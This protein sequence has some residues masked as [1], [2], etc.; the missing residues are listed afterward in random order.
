[1]PHKNYI[2]TEEH[3]ANIGLALK[4]R[5]FTNTWRQNL[6]NSLLGYKQTEEHKHKQSLVMLGNQNALGYRHTKE[7]KQKIREKRWK[8]IFPPKDTYIEIQLQEALSECNI[9]YEKH[10]PIIG[11]PDIFI[12]PN[13][14]IF[15]DGKYWHT[16]PGRQGYDMIVNNELRDL[17]YEVIRFW[18][19]DIRNNVGS[20]LE[21]IMF[22][23][24]Q[25][26]ERNSFDDE[27]TISE[28]DK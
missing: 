9:E 18:G 14:C 17:G 22:K 12:K 21:K 10:K 15:A 3:R 8:Q 26:N 27:I 6:S 23:L 24:H 13:I 20:C 28:E 4:G 11:Q 7:A 1:M 19:S 16:L 2:Q 5:I 25:C